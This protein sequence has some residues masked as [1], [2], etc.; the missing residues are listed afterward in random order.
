MKHMSIY[1][2]VDLVNLHV[3][4]ALMMKYALFA[5]MDSDFMMDLIH[6]IAKHAKEDAN[7]VMKLRTNARNAL[8]L[9]MQFRKMV[10][11]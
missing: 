8:I 5:M 10:N 3:Q 9:F 6:L 7:D 2:F 4:L 11:M 1:Q